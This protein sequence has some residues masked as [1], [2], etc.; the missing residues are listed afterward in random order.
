MP[1]LCETLKIKS[2]GDEALRHAIAI[3]MIWH[4]HVTHFAASTTPEGRDCLHLY[5]TDKSDAKD[6]K[7]AR[8]E[9]E[10]HLLP[11]EL[12]DAESVF[13]FVRGWL[14]AKGRDYGPMSGGDG[15]DVKGF[16]VQVTSDF[17]EVM[18]ITARYNYYSK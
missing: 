10:L 18:T 2:D 9:R 6:E 13:Q 8:I 4:R 7:Y 16:G 15:S 12:T 14:N 3:P 1:G 5:W 11:Y 17:Y